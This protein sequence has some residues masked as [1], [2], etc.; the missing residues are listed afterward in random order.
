MLPNII[1]RTSCTTISPDENNLQD[2][3][4]LPPQE[5]L[6]S[7]DFNAHFVIKSTSSSTLIGSTVGSTNIH[8][9]PQPDAISSEDIPRPPCT[10][11]SEC[12]STD[13]PVRPSPKD[14]SFLCQAAISGTQTTF[15]RPMACCSNTL[16]SLPDDSPLTPPPMQTRSSSR[17][18]QQASMSTPSPS[19]PSPRRTS[20]IQHPFMK[21]NRSHLARGASS[22]PQTSILAFPDS[23]MDHSYQPISPFCF[24]KNKMG[25]YEISEDGSDDGDGGRLRSGAGAALSDYETILKVCGQRGPIP[26]DMI[27]NG[28]KNIEKIGEGVYGEVYSG[29][30]RYFSQCS[31]VYKVVA[32]AGDEMVNGEKQKGFLEVLPEVVVSQ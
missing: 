8:P 24:K 4:V 29:T 31:W 13:I 25:R 1:N 6:P 17:I 10:V 16:T 15:N 20:S 27:F 19:T 14:L 11:V 18:A 22:S 12:P 30:F 5:K 3:N 28:V 26:L 7:P 32:I 23:P 9:E 2:L 21:S